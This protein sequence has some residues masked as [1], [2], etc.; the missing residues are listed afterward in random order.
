MEINQLVDVSTLP[1]CIPPVPAFVAVCKFESYFPITYPSQQRPDHDKLWVKLGKN[2]FLNL[3]RYKMPLLNKCPRRTA[4]NFCLPSNR[5]LNG[6]LHFPK[7]ISRRR[8]HN[9]RATVDELQ[10]FEEL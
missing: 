2:S 8:G 6:F 7:T 5:P 4:L 1:S 3:E 10:H 9:E